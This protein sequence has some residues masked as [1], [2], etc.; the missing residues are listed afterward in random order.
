MKI[1]TF[2]LCL[3]LTRILT[4]QNSHFSDNST[5]PF[6][7]G[8][9][10]QITKSVDDFSHP[11]ISKDGTKIIVTK[12]AYVGIYLIDVKNPNQIVT[13]TTEPKAGLDA[14]WS[15]DGNEIL[16]KKIY[17]KAMVKL[18]E[19]RLITICNTKLYLLKTLRN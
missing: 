15:K 1:T 2:I 19:S 16:F 13:V 7:M 18:L 4:A 6:Q 9:S 3:F 11:K 17:N 14:K 5:C 10:I 12:A 8:E